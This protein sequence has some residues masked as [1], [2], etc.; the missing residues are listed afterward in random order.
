MTG[1]AHNAFA[2]NQSGSQSRNQPEP[3]AKHFAEQRVGYQKVDTVIPCR[4]L[5]TRNCKMFA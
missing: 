3:A 2:R 5:Y 4:V 1:D